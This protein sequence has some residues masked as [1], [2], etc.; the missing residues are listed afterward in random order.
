MLRRTSI[1][2]NTEILQNF[3]HDVKREHA[4]V[5]RGN[6]WSKDNRYDR[7]NIQFGNKPVYENI[8]TT[9]PNFVNVN[10]EFILWTGY[11]EQMNPLVESFIE[12][13]YTYWGNSTE[14]KFLSTTDSIADASE[15]TIDGE[16]LIRSTFNLIVKAYL[17][18]EETNSVVTNR[19]SQTQKKITPSRIV[20]GYEGDATD[21]EV[22]KK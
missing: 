11:I 8:V 1:E 5:V 13:N 18:P 14:Y 3:E 16:R 21:Y 10:Y 20:F 22:G 19:I 15:M 12:Q 9:M 4:Q 6:T 17:L 2:R 7:F